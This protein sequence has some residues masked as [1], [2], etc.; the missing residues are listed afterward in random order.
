MKTGMVILRK[1]FEMGFK[2]TQEKVENEK[3]MEQ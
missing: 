3:N 2:G 1:A